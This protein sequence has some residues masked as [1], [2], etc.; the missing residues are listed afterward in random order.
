VKLSLAESLIGRDEELGPVLGQLRSDSQEALDTLRDLAR[1]IYPPLLAD[2]G[3]VAAIESQAKKAPL[4]VDVRG[5]GVGR[6]ASEIEA[7]L[8]FSVLEALQNVVKYA[9][10]T[11]ATVTLSAHRD[12]LTF[13]VTDDGVG[14]DT[15]AVSRG[16]GLQSMSDRLEALG[17]SL[18]VRSMPGGG[19]TVGGAVRCSQTPA[20]HD[21]AREPSRS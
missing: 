21:L 2:H 6:Y 12:S 17:G 19:T 1:G 8:Y 3:L 5:D 10:A 15:E 9:D 13:E 14:F 7:A 18:V 20:A 16:I 11:K 4:P